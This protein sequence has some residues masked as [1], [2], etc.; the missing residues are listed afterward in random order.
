MN[1]STRTARVG[2]AAIALLATL[3]GCGGDSDFSSPSLTIGGAV[4]GLAAGQSVVLSTANGMSV[5]VSQN[6]SYTFASPLAFDA[7]YA[8]TVS[9]QPVGQTCSI[10]NATGAGVTA[11]VSNINVSCSALTYPVGGTVTGLASG[12]TLALAN[13]ADT[14]SVTANGTFTFAVPVNYDGAYAVSVASQ[15]SGQVCS[16]G[17]ATGSGVTAAVTNVAVTCQART[18]TVSGTA[19]GLP[20]GAQ[21]TLMNN[22]ADALVVTANGAF[23]FA[24]PVAE[25]GSYAVTVNQQPTGETCTVSQGSGTDVGANVTDVVLSCSADT[26]TVGGTVSGLASGTQVTLYDNNADALVVSSDGSFTFPT[27][28][29][30]DGSYAVTVNQQPAGAVCTVSQASGSQVESNVNT[31]AVSCAA[32]TNILSTLQFVQTQVADAQWN[33]SACT[34]TTTCVIYADSPGTAYKTPFTTGRFN[35]TSCGTGSYISFS[36]NLV[37][38]VQDTTN[39]WAEGLYSANGTLCAAGGT[40]HFVIVGTDAQ[41]VPYLFYVGSDNNTG[42]LVSPY[43]P[44]TG[45][46][47]TFT[48][49]SHPTLAQINTYLH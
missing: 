18:F 28:I 13:G 48:G 21:V 4:T 11:N 49:V 27:P 26:Y 9:Q 1:I 2:V 8:V 46:G 36:E 24:T 23:N 31:V 45:A 41:S 17:N 38:G 22:G 29:S 39:P 7:A 15:P 44:L 14:A 5:T 20:S 40:G 30:W 37:N 42:T 6:A 33:V 3:Y 10:A 34:T 32:S 43:A 19:T 35:F 25:G 47:V 12:T 16:V